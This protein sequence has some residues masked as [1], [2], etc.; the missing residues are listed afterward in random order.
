MQLHL[1]HYSNVAPDLITI[2]EITMKQ[3]Y[4]LKP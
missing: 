2:I 3:A 1:L 4:F